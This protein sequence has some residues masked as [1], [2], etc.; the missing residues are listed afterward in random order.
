LID[1]SK[2]D[3]V[4]F[5]RYLV[6]VAGQYGPTVVTPPFR[7]SHLYR[8][9]TFPDGNPVVKKAMDSRSKKQSNSEPA[10][11][12]IIFMAQFNNYRECVI[13]AADKD[14]AKGRALR[15]ARFAVERGPLRKHA[16]VYKDV[17]EFSNDGTTAALPQDWMGAAGSPTQCPKRTA[18]SADV[19]VARGQRRL[20]TTGHARQYVY[21]T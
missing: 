5:L 16:K 21:T 2:T 7:G 12:G 6:P 3:S 13:A 9:L 19:Y 4:R 1:E 18:G 15:A 8:V 11:G 10:A 20:D 14:Q 17:I